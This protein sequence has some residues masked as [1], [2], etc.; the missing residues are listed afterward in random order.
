MAD[1]FYRRVVSQLVH[2]CSRGTELQIPS[3][4]AIL[5]CWVS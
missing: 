3:A 1:D 5:P 2:L 4:V